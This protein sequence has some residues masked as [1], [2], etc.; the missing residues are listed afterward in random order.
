MLTPLTH[1]LRLLS[2]IA[3][4]L[5]CL[6]GVADSAKAGNPSSSI[7]YNEAY[8]DIIRSDPDYG[9]TAIPVVSS[10][11]SASLYMNVPVGS[12]NK[13][14]EWDISF[15]QLE[16]T[17]TFS[18]DVDYTTGKTS[19]AFPF[20]DPYTSQVAGSI[21]MSWKSDHFLLT[22][23]TSS[24]FLDA[25]DFYTGATGPISDYYD[26]T[27]TVGK[28][29]T[30]STI[31]LT[32]RNTYRYDA[33]NYLDL[34]T[35]NIIGKGDFTAPTVAISAPSPN[36][37]TGNSEFIVT[38]SAQDNIAVG[39]VYWRW[40]APGDDPG[41]GAVR[42]DDW[43]SVD[44]LNIPDSGFA[45]QAKWSTDVDMSYNGPGTNRLW[46]ASQDLSGRF[47]PI[48]TRQFFYVVP[49]T[50][51]LWASDGGR[52]V[53][54]PGVFDGANLII[55]R[56]Y[57]ANAIPASSNYIFMNWTD[58]GGTLISTSP[59]LRFLMEDG[60]SLNANFGP[61]PFPQVVGVYNGLFNP[62]NGINELDSGFITV[63]VDARGL[64]SGKL[65]LESG[66]YSFSGQFG[67]Y[68]NEDDP[69][70]ADANF[71]IKV[72]G[73]KPIAV[74]LHMAGAGTGAL[75]R[76]MGG[77]L[78]IFDNRLGRRVTSVID[79]RYS[80]GTAGDV[81][82]G[83]YNI[84]LPSS[85][86]T[87]QI[88]PLGVGFGSINLK[89]DGTATTTINLADQSPVLSC[90]SAMVEGGSLPLF[91]SAYS[92]KGIL[93]GWLNF[94]NEATTDLRGEN[95]RWIKRHQKTAYFADGF[96]RNF[97]VIGSQYVA[98]KGGTNVL[99]WTDGSLSYADFAFSG[100]GAVAFDPTA[101]RFS[102]PVNPD[103]FRISFSPTTGQ[104]NGSLASN[105][106]LPMRA[107]VL[108]KLNSVYGFF[109]DQNQ[110]GFVVFSKP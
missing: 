79:A 100:T 4:G 108:P 110:S 60:L 90:S 51:S 27:I 99:G 78:V 50:L 41:R 74:S 107:I 86:G 81:V 47:S 22:I 70:A 17:G 18:N 57:S 43:N 55:D 103:N 96:D 71:E 95:V 62:T 84:L 11:L 33:V 61:N 40:A 3:L 56:W 49:S 82:P 59:Q 36:L 69:D 8:R 28:F 52:A 87:T 67:F 12:F 83:L 94:T 34:N 68:G 32:G 5:L 93:I 104:L 31:Y 89:S 102:F 106:S 16:I 80:P 15:S 44:T 45:T 35:G 72:T 26:L 101:N 7:L 97:E 88:G 66:T 76:S 10:S 42:Y 37:T 19:V 58:G 9:A 54:G 73:S 30:T 21:H 85:Q 6:C 109:L 25:L 91:V 38:G 98:P 46:V 20:I 14:T 65:C 77:Q 24:D 105:P 92:G 39:A 2:V 48:Q 13:A 23:T 63:K 29:T 64:Y 75:N 53:G 1:F